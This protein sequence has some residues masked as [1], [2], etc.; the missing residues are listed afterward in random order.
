[1][2]LLCVHF[3]YI[4]IQA[5]SVWSTSE[6]GTWQDENS[7]LVIRPLKGTVSNEQAFV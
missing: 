6:R 5:F 3:N 1:M 4:K 2:R 7:D